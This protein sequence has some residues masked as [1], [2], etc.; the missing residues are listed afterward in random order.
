MAKDLDMSWLHLTPDEEVLWS[1]HRSFY[2]TFPSVVAGIVLVLIGV[3]IA[4]SGYSGWVKWLSVLPILAGIV[5]AVPPFLRW[6]SEWF[7]LTT[8][9]IYHKRGVFAQDVTQ[10]RLDRVQNIAASQSL[11]ERIFDYGTVT[12]HTAGTSTNNLVFENVANPQS[13]NG[14]LTEQLDKVSSRR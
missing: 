4:A 3:G 6:R 11:L 13:V 14:M 7:V 1:G 8:E 9:E 2:H 12:I 5:V 10:I